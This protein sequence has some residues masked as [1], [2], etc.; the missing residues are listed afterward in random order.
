MPLPKI[1]HPTFTIKLLLSQK[2]LQIRPMLVKE[3]KILL[4]A[5]ESGEPADIFAAV[6]QVCNN[7]LITKF[8]INTLSL[9]D[10]EYLFIKIRSVSVSNV[11]KV[12][13]KDLEDEQVYDFDVDLDKIELKWAAEKVEPEFKINDTVTMM[14]RFPPATLYDSAQALL[15]EKSTTESAETIFINS[16]DAIFEQENGKKIVVY[17]SKDV[18]PEQLKEFV[19]QLDVETYEKL[20][21]FVASAPSLYYKIEYE[22]KKGSKRVIELTTLN[23]FFTLV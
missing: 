21:Q 5:K 20:K 3:E 16:I 10:L 6:K 22:N 9:I 11:T 4:I 8:D 12:S 7:C 19:E 1:K 14:M 15:S 23:D 17:P 18:S 2:E 13:Y